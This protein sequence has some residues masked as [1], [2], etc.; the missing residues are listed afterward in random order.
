LV[1]LI[2]R[3]IKY[4]SGAASNC[5][6]SEPSIVKIHPAAVELEHVEGHTSSVRNEYS[7]A[8]MG[9][10]HMIAGFLPSRPVTVIVTR[11]HSRVKVI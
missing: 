4:D 2:V 9:L 8:S 10:Q 6:T 7:H 5:I 3:N 11:L 1:L